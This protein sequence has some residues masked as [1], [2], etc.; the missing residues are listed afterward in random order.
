MDCVTVVDQEI[1]RLRQ[2]GRLTY[3]TRKR[4]FQLD[5][6][7]PEDG[8]NERIEC[9]HLAVDARGNVLVW[10]GDART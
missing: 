3:S 7:A 2:R 5:E 4:H 8:K 9:Q 6:A 1:A 10:T